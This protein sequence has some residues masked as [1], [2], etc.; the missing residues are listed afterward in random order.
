MPMLL[1]TSA[2]YATVITMTISL[3]SRSNPR[4]HLPGHIPQSLADTRPRPQ[5]NLR[6]WL[7][8]AAMLT[9]TPA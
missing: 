6:G 7:T 5:P 8:Q 3:K 4:P 9:G 1:E 2:A